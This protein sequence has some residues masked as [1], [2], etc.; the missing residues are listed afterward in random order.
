MTS[1][2]QL[3]TEHIKGIKVLLTSWFCSYLVVGFYLTVLSKEIGSL[4]IYRDEERILSNNDLP[5]A[6]SI[7]ILPVDYFG[8]LTT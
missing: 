3:K 4:K 8:K 5:L 2:L 6:Y 7:F 1:H